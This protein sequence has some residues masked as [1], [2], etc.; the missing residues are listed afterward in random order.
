MKPG[1]SS[2]RA[3]FLG[4]CAYLFVVTGGRPDLNLMRAAY[5]SLRVA[6]ESPVVEADVSEV[7]APQVEAGVPERGLPMEAVWQSESGEPVGA[8]AG[9]P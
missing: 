8:R 2:A 5:R 3:E 6:K 4:F 7:E 1:P 9:R